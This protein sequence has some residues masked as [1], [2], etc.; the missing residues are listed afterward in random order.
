[1]K[2]R[3]IDL[4]SNPR[5]MVHIKYSLRNLISLKRNK[6]KQRGKIKMKN[7]ESKNV[8]VKN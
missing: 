8:L 4:G 1:M 5:K 2:Y 7:K 6:I 3:E